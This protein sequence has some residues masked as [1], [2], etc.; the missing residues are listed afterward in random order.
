MLS[1]PGSPWQ[2]AY[3]ESA[4]GTIRRECMDHVI[5]FTLHQHLKSFL[6]YY[7]Q[8]KAHLSLDKDAQELRPVLAAEVGSIVAIP[9][10]G[11]R[12]H[13]YEHLAA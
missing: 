2:R 13:R 11:V 4:I 6:P 5:V 8:S 12:H 7:H 1:A 10:V 3:V 9:Q